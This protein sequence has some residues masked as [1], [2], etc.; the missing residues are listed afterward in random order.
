MKTKRYKKLRSV[1]KI[2]RIYGCTWMRQMR[3]FLISSK[4]SISSKDGFEET[5]YIFWSS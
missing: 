1:I 5:C 3:R 4:D 2:I